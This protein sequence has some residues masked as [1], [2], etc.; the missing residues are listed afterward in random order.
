[1]ITVFAVAVG[2]KTRQ[3]LDFAAAS[4]P[5]MESELV[6]VYKPSAVDIFVAPSKPVLVEGAAP[7]IPGVV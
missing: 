5:V 6:M 4:K 1:M 3:K 2:V 7:L